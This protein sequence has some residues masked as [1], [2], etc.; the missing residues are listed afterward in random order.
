MNLASLNAAIDAAYTSAIAN[1]Q[2]VLPQTIAPNVTLQTDTY[3]APTGNGFRIVC[4]I[5]RE[6]GAF[7]MRVKNYGPDINSE[8]E[9]P[10]EGIEAAFQN[11]PPPFYSV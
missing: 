10:P 1:S 8:K 3:I 7:I 2:R 5:K 4:I 11:M 6:D 9:W